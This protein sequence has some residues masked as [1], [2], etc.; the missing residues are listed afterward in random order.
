MYGFSLSKIDLR[1][2]SKGEL[3]SPPHPPDRTFTGGFD[4]KSISIELEGTSY[5][6][7]YIISDTRMQ[8]RLPKD[9]KAKT[10]KLLIKIDYSFKIP[11]QGYGRCG[12]MDTKNGADYEIAQWYPRMEVYD[13][14]KGWNSL[15]F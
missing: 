9:L 8:I 14:L 1:N 15:P 5:K 12:F 3:T 4:I 6:A 13:D 10:G 7:D 11:P 2:H